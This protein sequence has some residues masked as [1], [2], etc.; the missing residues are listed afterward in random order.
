MPLL[1]QLA[2]VKAR[3]GITDTTDD[4]LLTNFIKFASA[5]FEGECNRSFERGA[6]LTEEFGGNE[7]DLRPSRY[8]IE[9]VGAFH[10]KSDETAGW[11]AQSNANYL[12]RRQ[13][14]VSLL[15]ALGASTQVLRLTYTG[16]YVLPGTTPGAGQTALPDDL[17]QACVEQVSYWYQRRHQL[18]LASVPT[19]ERT[20]YRVAELDLLPHV[21]KVLDRY[22]R[23]IC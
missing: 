12:I 17:E 21:R 14:I 15:T 19:A 7:I 11:V 18:G 6:S 2:T 16:G 23:I 13:C 22:Q 4:T 1:T 5:R 10:L 20:F 8:P 9:S 3:L